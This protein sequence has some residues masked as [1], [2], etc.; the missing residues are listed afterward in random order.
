MHPQ[1]MQTLAQLINTSRRF[2]LVTGHS[3]WFG[4]YYMLFP[5][6]GRNMRRFRTFC[7][8]RAA[9]RKAEGS[10]TNDVFYHLV[11]PNLSAKFSMHL[12]PDISRTERGRS[13]AESSHYGRGSIEQWSSHFSQLRYNSNCSLHSLL[14]YPAICVP[15]SSV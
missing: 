8:N 1:L 9:L 2:S 14:V 10:S 5:G 15:P 13:R 4:K 3:P 12:S 6:M 7:W 11:S